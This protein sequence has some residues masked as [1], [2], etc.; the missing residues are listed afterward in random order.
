MAS[1]DR[2]FE[3]T[4]DTCRDSPPTIW[5]YYVRADE[6]VLDE[7]KNPQEIAG[8]AVIELERQDSTAR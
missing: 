6:M 4:M 2:L 3:T 7:A 1:A 5:C 8:R